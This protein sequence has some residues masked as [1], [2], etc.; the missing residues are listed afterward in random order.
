MLSIALCT[1]NGEKYIE[2]Q[3][4]SIIKQTY[5]P[6]ELIISDDFSTDKTI[7][8]IE[9]FADKASFHVKLL[10]HKK[11]NGTVKN[12]FEA[13]DACSGD[14]IALCDQ[15]DIWCE[16]KLYKCMKYIKKKDFL[17]DEP[18]LLHTDLF[19]SD[20]NLKIISNSMMDSQKIKNEP[21]MQKALK[22]LLTQNYVTGCTIVFNKSL[23]R[24]IYPFNKDIIMHDWWLAL[25]A[26]VY[27][28]IIFLDEPT[29]YYRQHSENQIGA[30]K[31]FSY[32]NILKLADVERTYRQITNTIMQVKALTA[33][34]GAHHS[35]NIIVKKY[36]ECAEKGNICKLISLKIGKQGRMRNFFFYVFFFCFR[37]KIR[38]LISA[39]A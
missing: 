14:Y 1:Y 2:E 16:D 3:L 38:N 28:E 5:Q 10:R 32:S 9:K 25:L 30:G 4:Q 26:A 11:N 21:D 37:K 17:P 22:V 7:K 13:I 31:Y 35:E 8:I 27:G 23:K 24:Y 39:S 19:V 15:D 12:F 34:I 33:N 18:V 36:L 20:K 29:L 6:D